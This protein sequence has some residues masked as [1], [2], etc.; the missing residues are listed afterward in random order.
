MSGAPWRAAVVLL[1]AGRLTPTGFWHTTGLPDDEVSQSYR[2]R[3]ATAVTSIRTK[4][5]RL[6][7]GTTTGNLMNHN[8]LKSQLPAAGKVLP[9]PSFDWA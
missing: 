5:T 1:S 8:M 6:W 3:Q 9:L 2:P 4:W 7:Q